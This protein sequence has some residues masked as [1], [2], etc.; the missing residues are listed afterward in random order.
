MFVETVKDNFFENFTTKREERYWSAVFS[1]L[2][3]S[4]NFRVMLASFHLSGYVA[5]DKIS[6]KIIL[7]GKMTELSH[8]SRICPDI[9]SEALALFGFNLRMSETISSSSIGI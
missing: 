1:K 6:P 3:V 5:V 9:P 2:F 4:L 7:R 8:K